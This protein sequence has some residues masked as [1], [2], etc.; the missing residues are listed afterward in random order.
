M[1]KT[2]AKELT[3]RTHS[4]EEY[5]AAVNASEILFG[6]G[7]EQQLSELSEKMF[8]S[9]FEGVPQIEIDKKLLETSIP[10]VDFLADITGIFTSKGEVR[11][12]LKDNGIAVNKSKIGEA[13]II[14]QQS[15]INQKYILIQKGKKNYYLIRVE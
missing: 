1:Q 13:Y 6:K 14:S 2:L 10:I 7:T 15:L 3:V 11:R 4:L 8:L 12:M 9:V 5:E